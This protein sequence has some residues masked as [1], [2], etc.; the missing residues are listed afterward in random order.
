MIEEITEIIIPKVKKESNGII[1]N[2]R[3]KDLLKENT[4]PRDEYVKEQE[5]KLLK[6]ID[7]LP[8]IKLDIENTGYY[9]SYN[10]KNG[11]VEFLDFI[12]DLLKYFFKLISIK[13]YCL[14][15]INK[16]KKIIPT[17]KKS[18]PNL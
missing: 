6:K 2:F 14:I 8:N 17:I 12:N 15:I 16:I 5:N 13:K 7:N 4:K 10:N 3:I 11:N 1:N 9:K 18:N